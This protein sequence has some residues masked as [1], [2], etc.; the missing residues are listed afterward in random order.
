MRCLRSWL[1]CV[2]R[3]RS[4]HCHQVRSKRERHLPSRR[5]LPVISALVAIRQTPRARSDGGRNGA[6][7]TTIQ[8]ARLWRAGSSVSDWDKSGIKEP[9]NHSPK[10]K[11][12][13]PN[14]NAG[15]N[16]AERGGLYC[17]FSATLLFSVTSFV[18]PVFSVVSGQVSAVASVSAVPSSLSYGHR[19]CPK[20]VT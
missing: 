19:K 12:A 9:R 1:Q 5:D 11:S 17:S 15:K 13:F 20:K 10:P 18:K 14:S 4:F 6:S 16:L 7:R 3:L 8:R 2:S